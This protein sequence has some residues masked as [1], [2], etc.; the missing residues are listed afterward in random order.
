MKEK[1]RVKKRRIPALNSL[2]FLA[3]VGV[4]GYHL[5]PFE[6]KGGY[7]GVIIFF[8]LSGFLLAYN[9]V[10]F[11]NMNDIIKFYKH[12]IKRIFPPMIIM[13]LFTMGIFGMM[14]IDGFAVCKAE[15]ISLLGGYNNLWQN[16]QELSYFARALNQSPYT[17][18]WSLAVELQFYLMWP[19]ISLAYKYFERE[20]D[21]EPK[22]LALI[23]VLAVLPMIIMI[24]TDT[25]ISIIYYGTLARIGAI[26][27]G[28]CVAKFKMYTDRNRIYLKKKT[29]KIQCWAILA[30]VIWGYLYLDSQN[31]SSYFIGIPVYTFL[32]GYLIWLLCHPYFKKSILKSVFFSLMAMLSYNIY[33]WMFPTIYFFNLKGVKTSFLSDAGIVL[34]IILISYIGFIFEMYSPLKIEKLTKIYNEGVKRHAA[35][36]VYVILCGLFAITMLVG[37]IKI[38]TLPMQVNNDELKEIEMALYGDKDSDED[39]EKD[40]VVDNENE[41]ILDEE[42]NPDKSNEFIESVTEESKMLFI[43]DSVMKGAE[44]ALQE[45]YPEATIDADTSRQVKDTP[46]IIQSILSDGREVTTAIIALGINGPFTQSQG[47]AVVDCFPEDCKIYWVNVYG[48]SVSW[49]SQS[50]DAITEL[51]DS[52]KNVTVID[53]WSLASQNSDWLYSDNIHL[54]LDGQTGYANLLYNTI[55]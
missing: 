3:M 55:K 23:S 18:L 8:Q 21:I 26:L 36:F 11:N 40:K 46:S 39:L 51:A 7:L 47:Q 48:K 12:K 1:A 5:R 31:F 19:F 32:F 43:G 17:H 30:S 10:D 29:V 41:E 45:L 53:W 50:N 37:G 13:I 25:D 35:E 24:S 28:T 38:I 9:N 52:N 27:S 6:L 49:E 34:V 16:S 54:K 20:K 22:W 2:R 14:D 42:S 15:I 33:L 4:I 44:I